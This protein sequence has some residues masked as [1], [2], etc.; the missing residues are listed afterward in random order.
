MN[1]LPKLPRNTWTYW[2][3]ANTGISTLA[4]FC[5][6]KLIRGKNHSTTWG[7][8]P[9]FGWLGILLK[10]TTQ[11]KLVVHSH[12]IEALRFRNRKNGGGAFFGIMKNGFTV[13]PIP[14]SLSVKKT[15]NMPSHVSKPTRPVATPSP[16]ALKYRQSPAIQTGVRPAASLNRHTISA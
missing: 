6:R 13:S 5:F 4:I 10:W 8:H 11:V 15:G 9:Y 12:N 1:F 2:V 16:M 3:R 7:T 14:A